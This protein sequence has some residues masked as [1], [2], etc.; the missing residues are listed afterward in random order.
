MGSNFSMDSL[1]H[2]MD[3]SA[4][5]TRGQ[6]LVFGLPMNEDS[7]GA[8]CEKDDTPEAEHVYHGITHFIFILCAATS[9]RRQTISA[10]S[11]GPFLGTVPRFFLVPGKQLFEN[12]LSPRRPLI[13]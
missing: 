12:S 8:I 3:W 13:T 9:F 11:G 5:Y 6:S 1:T 10:P 2:K 4:F 7:S